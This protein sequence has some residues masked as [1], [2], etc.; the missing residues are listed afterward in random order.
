MKSDEIDLLGKNAIIT[1]GS[2]GIGRAIALR[3]A[4]YGCNIL[5][6][7]LKD[8]QSAQDVL[9]SLR[10]YN[11]KAISYK[12]DV[13]NPQISKEMIDKVISE[14]ESID[15]LVNNAGIWKQG[16]IGEIDYN[17]W[18]LII[19]TN[20]D[21]A[22]NCCNVVIPCM[23]KQRS[24]KIIN[25]SS[26]SA[27]KGEAGSSAYVASKSALIGF[28]R[29]VAMEVGKYNI[30]VNCIAPAW[31]ESDMTKEYM[32]KENRAE[33]ILKTIPLGRIAEPRDVA[34]VALFLA[35]DLSNY[36]TGETIFLSG[37]AI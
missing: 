7:Y 4:E 12:G 1:G 34:D 9:E 30:N 5:I 22:F 20:L 11:V 2:R 23:K 26:R 27:R 6:N 37:G 36:I 10:F 13:S 33:E 15:I 32:Y 18:R 3:L 8:D 14:F 17:H 24:G 25:I 35:S 28:T 29:S 21:S 16:F 19:K 31:V